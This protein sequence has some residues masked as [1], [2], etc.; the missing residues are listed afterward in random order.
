M[1]WEDQFQ[2][3]T[4]N[5]L[6]LDVSSTCTGYAIATCD[7]E[8]RVAEINKAGCLWLNSNWTHQQKYSYIGKS[9]LES[10]LRRHL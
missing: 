8:T 3:D 10:T 7:F 5:I 9:I 4:I 1:N 2:V 6:F